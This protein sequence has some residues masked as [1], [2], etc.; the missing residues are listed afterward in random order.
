[1]PNTILLAGQPIFP[2]EVVSSE[3]ITP[4]H[5]VEYASGL[6]R[7][8]ATAAGV[9]S[10]IFALENLVPSLT[11]S[12]TAPIDLAWASGDSVRIA[13]GRPG[14]EFYAW[15]TT[16]QT[17]VKGDFLISTGDGTV[18]K[19]TGTL[20]DHATIAQAEE[21]VTTTG[22]VARLRVRAM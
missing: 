4:G 5:L 19:I 16:S 18:K 17:I 8:H 6:L 3:A 9:A 22:A 2:P 1:M 13:I 14:D 15:L 20:V 11:N 12:Q 10:P 7:K 21:A